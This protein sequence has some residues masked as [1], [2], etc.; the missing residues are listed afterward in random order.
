MSDQQEAAKNLI[1]KLLCKVLMS[2]EWEPKCTQSLDN[3]TNIRHRI[4][5]GFYF[6]IL[7]SLRSYLSSFNNRKGQL[8][9]FSWGGGCTIGS[10][11]INIAEVESTQT[12]LSMMT[13]RE[14][15]FRPFRLFIVWWD[16]QS[17]F[18]MGNKSAA[19]K[20]LVDDDMV[21][22]RWSSEVKSFFIAQE[23]QRPLTAEC[24]PYL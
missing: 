13:S 20:G 2:E 12:F 7:D 21:K 16:L 11:K 14:L 17:T 4:Y 5:R 1:K 19:W 15:P 22:V 23:F 8:F 3:K 18:H 9:D 6:S 24:L 10:Y